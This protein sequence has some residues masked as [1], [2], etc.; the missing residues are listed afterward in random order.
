MQSK[1]LVIFTDIGDTVIDEATEYRK[2]GSLVVESASCIPGAKETMLQLYREGF[3][4]AMVADGL[5][6]S[7]H[8]SMTQNGLDGIFSARVI[9]ELVHCH[10]PGK[11]MFAEA[12]GRLGLNDA[13]K[14][15]VIMVGNDVTRDVGGANAYGIRSVHL[16]WS[17]RHRCIPEYPMEEA[18]YTIHTPSE[19]YDL[20]HR[21]EGEL[22]AE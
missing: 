12:M 15:R 4:I 21:L 8:N 16:D 5:A 17:D 2:P 11:R 20:C 19:L 18:T 14:K 22:Q 3:T 10:K 9:S 7:F 6:Q 13:D 1:Q